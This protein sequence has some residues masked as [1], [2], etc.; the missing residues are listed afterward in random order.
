MKRLT[1][2]QINAMS[3]EELKR[4]LTAQQL[5]IEHLLYEN[6][7]L[8]HALF[9]K[10]SEK[11]SR[12]DMA[13]ALLFNE[14]EDS[15]QSEEEER[16]AKIDVALLFV[17]EHTR[18]RPGRRRLPVNLPRREILHDLSEEEKTCPLHGAS[19]PR[20]GE[21]VSERLHIIPMQVEVER[22]VRTK[23]GQCPICKKSHD[24]ID[25]DAPSEVKMAP[26]PKSLISGSIITPALL[27]YIITAKFCDALPFYRL[28]KIFARSG[29]DLSRS[30]MS[31]WAITVAKKGR[32]LRK[33]MWDELRRANV[34]H[35][36][37]T[38]VQVLKEPGRKP[39]QK[40]YMWAFRSRGDK[41]VVIFEYRVNRGG[42]F[43]RKRL[44]RFSGTFMADGY[45]GY[46]D[47]STSRLKNV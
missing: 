18:K 45:A 33:L 40:S 32:R 21:D 31:S 10:K 15:A 46:E 20:I 14:I 44:R 8:R 39:T 4:Y 7:Q 25:P 37:E 12:Y 13:Q 34:I 5:R 29:V 27:A 43:L 3:A 42:R 36:D 30:T 1:D 17:Q 23:Y 9:G 26:I 28:E 35:I 24:P 6:A 11:L 2:E 19:F 16:Q 47:F 22:H 41:P 38:T